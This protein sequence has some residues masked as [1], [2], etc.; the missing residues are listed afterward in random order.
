[1]NEPRVYRH[2]SGQYFLILLAMLLLGGALFFMNTVGED[3]W[4]VVFVG[5]MF[6]LILIYGIFAVSNSI[7]I[8]DTE[9]TA[10]NLLGEKNLAWGE[11]QQVSGSSGL[12]LKNMDGDL[13]ISIQ[14]ELP[15]FEEIVDTVGEKRPDLFSAQQFPEINSGLRFFIPLGLLAILL[16]GALV[17][18]V[19]LSRDFAEV[20]AAFLMPMAVLIILMLF[21]LGMSLTTPRSITMDGHT[22]TVRYLWR[23]R[24]LA[25]DE[26]ESVALKFQSTR[27]GRV[28]YPVLNLKNGK[29]MR[30]PGLKVGPAVMYL[31]LKEWH[32]RQ[33]GVRIS[34]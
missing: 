27:N 4:E 20:S 18:L 31:V 22:L 26:I 9:I 19:Y 12:K 24:I 15:G 1:M 23:E 7:I 10:K 6:L 13:T 32:K 5:V 21:I 28:Y 29:N 11:I 33:T 14:S 3:P 30:I 34:V 8:T 25:A 16:G 17:V 2:P